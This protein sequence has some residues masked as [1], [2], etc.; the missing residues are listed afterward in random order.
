MMLTDYISRKE[1]GT[2]LTSIKG[3][4]DPSIQRLKDYIKS[5]E[6]D[7]LQWHEQHEDEQKKYN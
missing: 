1:R 3:S 4:V 5:A 7:R 6:E 2:G